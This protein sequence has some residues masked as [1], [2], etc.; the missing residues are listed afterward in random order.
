MRHPRGRR[1]LRAAPTMGKA[2]HAGSS[3]DVEG[4]S[5]PYSG[6]GTLARVRVR[7]LRRGGAGPQESGGEVF[8]ELQGQWEEVAR[9]NA[10]HAATT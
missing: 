7:A 9:C 2:G 1:I 5:A 6:R 8:A 10:L 3:C 4:Q